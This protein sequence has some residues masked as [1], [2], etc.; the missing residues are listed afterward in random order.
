M[1]YI[2]HRGFSYGRV[3]RMLITAGIF[4]G[5]RKYSVCDQKCRYCVF[6]LWSRIVLD[7]LTSNKYCMGVGLLSAGIAFICIFF[8]KTTLAQF[9]TFFIRAK[10]LL[11]RA[12]KPTLVKPNA[13]MPVCFANVKNKL[14]EGVNIFLDTLYSMRGLATNPL[15]YLAFQQY[16]QIS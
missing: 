8:C 7:E 10:L 1:Y 3:D 13:H 4:Q 5:K 14:P 16:F 2:W 6:T 15:V 12:K 11:D 9:V